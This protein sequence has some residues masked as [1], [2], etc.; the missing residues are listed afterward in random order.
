MPRIVK[1]FGGYSLVGGSTFLIDLLLVHLFFTLGMSEYFAIVLG[2]LIAV[3]INFTLSYRFVFAGTKR[4]L[5][6]GYLYFFVIACIGILFIGPATIFL[7]DIF[8]LNL[9][10]A[11]IIVGGTAGTINFFL[12]NFLNFKM[13]IR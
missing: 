10:I 7:K 13:G 5:G 2:F 8:A 6:K 1:R 3:S 9:Y 11:R 4:T 12:N